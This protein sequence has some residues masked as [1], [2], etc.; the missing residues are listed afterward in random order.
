MS[1]LDIDTRVQPADQHDAAGLGGLLA[2]LRLGDPQ[3]EGPLIVLPLMTTDDSAGVDRDAPSYITLRQAVAEGRLEI[4]EVSQA[5]TVAQ[6]LFANDGDACVLALDGEHVSGLN[7]DR[8][9]D[10]PILVDKRSRLTVPVSCVER[11]RW[12]AGAARRFEDSEYMAERSV[13]LHMKHSTHASMRTG[14]RAH[15]DQWGVWDAV[16]VLHAKHETASRT[17]AM[18][19]AYTARADGLERILAAFDCAEGQVGI[20]VLHGSRVVGLDYVSRAPQYAEV[21][22]RLLR[23]YALEALVSGGEPGDAAVADS[24]LERLGSLQGEPYK[25]VGLGSDVRFAGDGIVGHALVYEAD[26][27]HASFFESAAG[28]QP[29]ASRHSDHSEPRTTEAYGRPGRDASPTENPRP[30]GEANRSDRAAALAQYVRS[31]PGFEFTTFDV[32]YHHMGALLTDAVLQ[33]FGVRYFA[34]VV[35]RVDRVRQT[36]PHLRTTSEFAALLSVSDPHVVLDWGGATAVTRL[37]A[38][39]DLLVSEG[40]ETEAELLDFLDRPGSRAKVTAISGVASKT[41]S[42]VRFLCGAEDAVAVDRHLWRHLADAG[43]SADDFD[44]AVR[45]YRDAAAIL[46]VSPATL[47]FSLFSRSAKRRRRP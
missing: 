36:Y 47:E 23:S 10:V 21:H 40:V 7:Q 4:S 3:T 17:R 32:P 18:R 20:L 15:A 37:L 14:A 12:D 22:P 45:I 31:L 34:Q 46:G 26:V 39:T 42:Y 33:A 11:G 24:F 9:L 41:Y 16:D 1:V 19:D 2:D 35:P 6:L 43:I 29:D 28:G 8:I 25:A 5:G 13:R 30:A 44:D 27:V 38:L